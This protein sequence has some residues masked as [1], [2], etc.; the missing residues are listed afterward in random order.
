MIM[1]VGNPFIPYIMCRR[2]PVE[3]NPI[4]PLGLMIQYELFLYL[5]GFQESN[6]S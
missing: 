2:G 5:Q 3:T 4:N 6:P 1:T